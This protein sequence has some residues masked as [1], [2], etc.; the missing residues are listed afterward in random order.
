M[1]CCVING[2]ELASLISFSKS[3][4]DVLYKVNE[5]KINMGGKYDNVTN[6][7]RVNNKAMK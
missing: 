3:T 2:G 6:V 7:T 4:N 1:H 5:S